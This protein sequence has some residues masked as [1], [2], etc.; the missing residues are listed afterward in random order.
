MADYTD[1][2]RAIKQTAIEAVNNTTPV[3]VVVGTVISPS[4]IKIQ[5]DQKLILSSA[6]IVL[7]RNV[8]DFKRDE[9]VDHITEKR[10]GGSQYALF[11]SHDHQYKGK[12]EFEIHNKLEAGEK[13]L[14]IREQGGKH[15]YV[16]DRI[17]K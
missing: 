4:P 6:Q 17:A 7:T 5:V 10:A 14:M 13:V 1:L 15:Y 3:A 12:K 2:L 9:T 8:T 11:E 16:I